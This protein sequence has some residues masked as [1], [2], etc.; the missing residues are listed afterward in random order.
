MT[1]TILI[2]GATSGFGKSIAEHFAADGWN[3]ILV[4]RRSERLR[5][6]SAEL[7]EKVAVLPITLDV[8]QRQ[9]VMETLTNLPENFNAVDVL[10]NNAGLAAGLE[11]AQSADLDNWDAM[12]DTNIKG[13]MYVTR[14][15][16]PGMV[17][18]NTGH[19]VNIGSV[20]GSYPYEGGNVY[21][22]TKAFVAQFS[23]NLRSDV[24]GTA[25]RV[26]NIKP[27]N[28]ETE[29]SL[30]R[31]K[32]NV[33]KAKA[34]YQGYQPLTAEDIAE[35]VFWVT[36]LPAHVNVNELEVMPVAQSWAGYKIHRH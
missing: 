12:V 9:A 2:T 4:G 8:R 34:V 24:S 35:M 33:A 5:V 22:A 21:G 15:I 36:H 3:L 32:G 7:G 6:I 19:I 30:V 10:V 11:P 13:L 28:A 14:A 29:F 23:R 20:A 31:F 27:G 18:R 1:K 26:T 16:L 17:A 25:I